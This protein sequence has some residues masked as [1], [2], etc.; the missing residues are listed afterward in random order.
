MVKIRLNLLKGKVAPKSTMA[1]AGHMK[2]IPK[3]K[4]PDF[5][6]WLVRFV[7]HREAYTDTRWERLREKFGLRSIEELNGA[8]RFGGLIFIGGSEIQRA[9]LVS[10]LET[11]AFEQEEIELIMNQLELVWTESEDF[12]KRARYESIP[13]LTSLRWRVDIR[14]ASSNYL[15]KPEV[16][17]LLRIGTHDGSETDYIFLELDKDKL[18]WLDTMIGKI[19][20]E[21]LKAEEKLNQTV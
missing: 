2:K 1:D 19:K 16:V 5:L 13:S 10:D 21:F 3:E 12:L 20:R 8:Q 11:L 6:Q 4:L 7:V 14:T 9:E 17:A 15:R 18:S